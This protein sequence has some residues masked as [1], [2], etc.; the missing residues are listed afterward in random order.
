MRC[1]VVKQRL[2]EVLHHYE[3]PASAKALVL[4]IDHHLDRAVTLTLHG[5]GYIHR[6]SLK[7]YSE[8][9]DEERP[10]WYYQVKCSLDDDVAGHEFLGRCVHDRLLV[11]GP[12]PDNLDLEQSKCY[13]AICSRPNVIGELLQVAWLGKLGRASVDR[14]GNWS[15][16][17][18][19]AEIAQWVGLMFSQVRFV[20]GFG[21]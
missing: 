6:G 13:N 21:C 14:E 19:V 2:I 7:A 8:E 4:L 5:D 16:G 3:S 18:F 11:V 12:A 1:Q 9:T 17:C 15:D 20:S 10:Q